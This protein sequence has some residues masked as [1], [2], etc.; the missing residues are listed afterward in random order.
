M[1]VNIRETSER[2]YIYIYIY[3]YV[4]IYDGVRNNYG[5]SYLKF[6]VAQSSGTHLTVE[7]KNQ[8]NIIQ[9]IPSF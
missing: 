2:I 1:I 6:H 5:M 7:L 3:I 4:V 9:A 8:K